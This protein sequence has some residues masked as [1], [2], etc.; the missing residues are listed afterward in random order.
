MAILTGED[1]TIHIGSKSI[2]IFATSDVSLGMDRG[3]IEQ[4]LVGQAGNYF[5]QGALSIDGSL[6]NCR[7]AASGNSD[8]LDS[9]V[10]GTVIKISGQLAGSDA[11]KFAFASCQ[12]SG[13]DV[14]VGDSSTI[15]E[16][17]IDFTVMNPKDVTYDSSKVGDI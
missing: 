10:D 14:T 3:V 13:Y 4:E 2:T 15:T 1:A 12:V 5:T 6:T 7:F 8:F 17:S 9:I 11:L 16:A